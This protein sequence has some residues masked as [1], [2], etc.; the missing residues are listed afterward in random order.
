MTRTERKLHE[1]AEHLWPGSGDDLAIVYRAFAAHGA[2]AY[3]CAATIATML[4]GLVPRAEAIDTLRTHLPRA[5][6]PGPKMDRAT[7]ADAAL[8]RLAALAGGAS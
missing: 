3:W 4:H 8:D 2:V 7:A 6:R 1:G 5:T